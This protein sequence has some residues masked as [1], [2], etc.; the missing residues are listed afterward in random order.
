MAVD[1][2]KALLIQALTVVVPVKNESANVHGLITE[3]D[4]TLGGLIPYE[5]I[6]IDDGST[7]D[8]LQQLVN[9]QIGRAHV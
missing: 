6:Y 8:T 5:I 3:I 1:E 7:D 4:Q 9:I 2:P